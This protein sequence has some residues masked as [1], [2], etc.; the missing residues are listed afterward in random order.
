M[1]DE[2]ARFETLPSAIARLR[3]WPM[4]CTVSMTCRLICWRWRRKSAIRF[5]DAMSLA[6][7]SYGVTCSILPAEVGRGHLLVSRWYWRLV[8]SE[9]IVTLVGPR[10]AVESF[11]TTIGA[12]VG[13]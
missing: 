1:D 2:L 3:E 10:V 4:T 13:Q 7:S 6:H 12:N 5:L 11:A 9:L 8:E